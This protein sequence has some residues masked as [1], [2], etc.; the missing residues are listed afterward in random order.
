MVDA[1]FSLFD[2]R[3]QLGNEGRFRVLRVRLDRRYEFS[4]GRHDQTLKLNPLVAAPAPLA[5]TVDWLV[6]L[7]PEIIPPPANFFR[8]RDF[9]SRA[10]SQLYAIPKTF[11]HQSFYL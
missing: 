6:G 5:L 11:P 4:V 1:V 2:E 8:I 7:I 9:S 3:R 10:I